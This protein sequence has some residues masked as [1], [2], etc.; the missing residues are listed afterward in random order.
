MWL[1][2][3]PFHLMTV[4]EDRLDYFGWETTR[5]NNHG[6]APFDPV[7]DLHPTPQISGGLGVLES[8]CLI[9]AG[10]AWWSGRVSLSWEQNYL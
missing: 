10:E 6:S 9:A 4:S 1:S 5:R 8:I 7:E 3:F 2:C